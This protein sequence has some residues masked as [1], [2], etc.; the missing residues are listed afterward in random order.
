M[1]VPTKAAAVV[2]IR[3]VMMEPQMAMVETTSAW[4]VPASLSVTSSAREAQG[5]RMLPMLPE[6]KLR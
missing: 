2:A 3:F 4:M 5:T 1:A 6:R